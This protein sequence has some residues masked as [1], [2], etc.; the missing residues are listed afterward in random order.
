MARR[1]RTKERRR[2][3][4]KR[5][6]DT[7][8]I[9]GGVSYL[10]IPDGFSLFQP[11]AGKYRLDFMSYEVK[12][13]KGT[14]GGNPF[15]EEG[16]LGFE[17]TYFI[18]RDIG[19]N[20]D[21]HL[22]AAKTLNK[23]CPICEYRAKLAKDPNADEDTIKEL[24]PKERQVFIVRDLGEDEM[25]L[26]EV[27]HHLFGKQLDAKIR[28]GDEED[29]YDFF[30]DPIDGLTVR[31]NFEQSDRGKWLEATDIEF[32]P[33]KEEYD[34]DI[35][36][37]MPD[38]DSLLHETPYDKLKRSFLQTEPESDDDIDNDIDDDD[39]EEEKPKAKSKR[40]RK[41]KEKIETADDFG[42][43]EGDT[44]QYEGS[45]CEI[46]RI[47]KDG[48][49]LTLEDEDG[50]TI[51]AVGA[52]EVKKIESSDDSDDDIPFEDDD[53]EE[54]EPPRKKKRAAKKKAA[55]KKKK[56]ARKKK[57]EPEPESDE[58]DDEGD[59]DDDEWDAWDDED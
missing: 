22:C 27:S 13:G 18:H 30:A 56:A 3:S 4:A 23:P 49:S 37:E 1:K 50:D 25:H 54:D 21:W 15:F 5:R 43:E 17:R 52:G 40:G 9:G 8:Q 44:V 46:V 16:E 57:K 53:E 33:R 11:K 2:A 36:E 41:K 19:P 20:K 31:V 14:P 29:G 55:P 45:E 42:L 26:F 28:S 39:D 59:D 24:G 38:L 48:T 47:S 35:V 34:E 6:V 58:D 10:D 7:H 51:K 12:K 32:R